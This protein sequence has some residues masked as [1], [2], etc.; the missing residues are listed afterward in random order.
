MVF[1]Q[2]GGRL[3]RGSSTADA[4]RINIFQPFLRQR[5]GLEEQLDICASCMHTHVGAYVHPPLAG[6]AQ[7]LS[8]LWTWGQ[9]TSAAALK[10]KQ[11]LPLGLALPCRSWNMVCRE[12]PVF[13]P[14]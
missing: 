11:S 12:V 8:P 13:P 2:R 14:R 6:H 5:S 1:K 4:W 3:S 7:A 9:G 10:L